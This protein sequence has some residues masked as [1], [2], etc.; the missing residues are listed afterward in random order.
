MTRLDDAA[1]GC[2]GPGRVDIVPGDH[3]HR[4]AGLL[5]LVD[6]FRYLF[7]DRVLTKEQTLGST[8]QS[9]FLLLKGLSH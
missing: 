5:A 9:S 3:A 7:T 2:D 4:D 6:R 1:L 8:S